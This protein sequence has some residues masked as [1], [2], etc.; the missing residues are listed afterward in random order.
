[1]FI[2]KIIPYITAVCVLHVAC[3]NH[4]VAANADS[5]TTIAHAAEIAPTEAAKSITAQIHQVDSIVSNIKTKQFE[6]K[7]AYLPPMQLNDTLFTKLYFNDKVPVKI[8]YT[9][10]DESG[11][12][13]GIANFYFNDFFSIIH[14][15]NFGDEVVYGV[16]T[17]NGK[18]FS[19]SKSNKDGKLKLDETPEE[20]ID[21]NT[22]GFLKYILDL[23]QLYPDFKFDIPV[24]DLKGDFALRVVQPVTLYAAADT[25]SAVVSKLRQNTRV[26]YL[27]SSTKRIDYRGKSWI[28]Y[29]VKNGEK[30][31]WV[32]GHPDW[33]EEITGEDF[34]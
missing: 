10:F 2:N 9:T 4:P 6:H 15:R 31:G 11:K 5:S 20:A 13:S 21:Y 14:E 26:G 30:I 33:I 23:T 3:N 28:W 8:S 17:R 7:D 32:V 24:V 34:D 19:F 25:T 12:P 1:M 18:Y 27:L 29:K 16:V 22:G